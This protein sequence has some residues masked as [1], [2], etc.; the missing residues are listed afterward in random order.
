MESKINILFLGGSKRV[1]VAEIFINAGKALNKKVN[2]FSY[3]LSPYEPIAEIGTIIKGLKWA[4]PDILNNLKRAIRGYDINIVV[5]FVDIATILCAKLQEQLP[6][7]YWCV[8]NE[9]ICN[10]LFDKSKSQDWFKS[11]NFLIPATEIKLP[12]IA[13]LKT[14]SGAKGIKFLLS[15]SNMDLFF[16][17]GNSDNYFLQEMIAG[18]E[19]SVDCFVGKM[20]DIV[21]VVPRK[22]LEVMNGEATRSITVKDEQVVKESINILKAGGFKGPVTIQ[23]ICQVNTGVLYLIEINP[24]FGSGILTSIRAGANICQFILNDYLGLENLEVLDWKEN[25]LMVRAFKEYYFY[26]TDN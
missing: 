10:I 16:R 5:P 13:K 14:G 1:S 11:N 21:S 9:N 4:D 3:E 20:G 6:Q 7:I 26:A 23:F 8:S 2:I 25:L 22:R 24:R 12:L 15:E 18:E 19:F 17:E